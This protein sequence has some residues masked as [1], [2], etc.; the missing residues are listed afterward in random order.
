MRKKLFV[1]RSITK[2]RPIRNL[3]KQREDDK[4]M[5]KEKNNEK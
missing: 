5:I 3:F 1:H 2:L 4:K